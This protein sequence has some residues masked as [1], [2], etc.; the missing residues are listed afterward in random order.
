MIRFYKPKRIIEIGSGNSTLMAIRAVKQNMR[1]D[2]RYNCEHI[3]IEPYEMKWLE[4]TSAKVIRSKVEDLDSSF[5]NV[6]E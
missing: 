1:E 3:C 5:F 4:K 6:L 2:L